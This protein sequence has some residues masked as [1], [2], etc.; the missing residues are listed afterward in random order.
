MIK[1]KLSKN[2]IK[3]LNNLSEKEKLRIKQKLKYLIVNLNET[4]NIPFQELDI[5]TL[6]GDWKGYFRLRIK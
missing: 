2:S 3:F 1:L 6:T 5:K 4:R